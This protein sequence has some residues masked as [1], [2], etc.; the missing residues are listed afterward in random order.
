M[1]SAV[2]AKQW[3]L[4]PPLSTAHPTSLENER[5]AELVEELKRE[6][7]YEL[8][9][10]TKQRM[11]ALS[12]L[13]KVTI[14]FVKEVSRKQRYPESQISQFGGK[15]FPYGS[16]RLGVFGPG[17]DIDTLTVAPKHVRR[18][19]FFEQYPTILRR[20]AGP[21]AIQSL[22]AVP[23]AFVPIIKL[24]L[25]NIEID[26]IFV[27]VQALTTIPKNLNLDDNKLLDGLDQ[28]SIKSITGPRVTDQILGLVPEHKTFRT[29]LRAIKLWAQRRA[30]YANIVGYPG[31]VAWAMLVAKVCQ[32]YPHAVGATI[33]NKFFHVYK[34]WNWPTPVMLKEIETGKE[35]TW[36]PMLYNGDK[37]NLMPIITP[38][39][40]SM[41]ST[42]NMTNSGK[43]IILKEFDRGAKIS[44]AIFNGTAKWSELFGKHTFFTKDF[45]YYISVIASAHTPDGAKGFSGMVESKVRL[46]VQELEKISDQISLARPFTKGFRRLHKVTSDADVGEVRKGS[47]KYQIEEAKA[48]KNNSPELV[49]D[50]G[51]T[52]DGLDT[53]PS[54]AN[55]F[56]YTYYIGIDLTSAAQ[57]NLNISGP[58]TFFKELCKTWALYKADTHFIDVQ[59]VKAWELPNDIF[60]KGESKPVR[61]TK[62][63]AKP[64]TAT[65][66]LSPKA[67]RPINEVEEPAT[68]GHEPKRQKLDHSS[69]AP[70]ATATGEGYAVR[71]D[72][73]H[74]VV[75]DAVR[76]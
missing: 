76:L 61:P 65:S 34:A 3:G 64:K 73:A 57:K 17:S 22:T 68:N 24:V 10:A 47:M 36:N 35:K 9:H 25:N 18:E 16:Y 4:S 48:V 51:K 50:G 74:D 69:S 62:K 75:S 66:R 56:T 53:G 67:T 41:C 55:F 38:A 2:P 12:L 6:N 43:K 31:G 13:Q 33:I 20:I 37:K 45:R 26:L 54:E 30:I 60:D 70:T 5:T 23:D 11:I 63:V 14:E 29:A 42:Y 71:S 1:A 72:C 32:L 52:M 15:I 28:Q 21:D 19:D 58:I 40:P 49:N 27:S 7:N 59:A 44:D 8:E 39:Y 46:L